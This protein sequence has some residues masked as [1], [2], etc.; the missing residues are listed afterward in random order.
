MCVVFLFIVK[1][2]QRTWECIVMILYAI[3]LFIKKSTHTQTYARTHTHILSIR[4]YNTFDY[5]YTTFFSIHSSFISFR[6]IYA[7][8]QT[9]HAAHICVSLEIT[10]PHIHISMSTCYDWN[11]YQSLQKVE[12]IRLKRTVETRV[13]CI[14]FF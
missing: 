3:S 8:M 10:V 14:F 9:T 5:S 2:L 1:A 11:I 4:Q 6:F 7:C 13:P 12:K